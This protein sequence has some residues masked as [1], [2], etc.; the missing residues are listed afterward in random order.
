V[1][2]FIGWMPFCCPT[3]SSREWKWCRMFLF[4]LLLAT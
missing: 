2:F 4:L 1:G 3:N